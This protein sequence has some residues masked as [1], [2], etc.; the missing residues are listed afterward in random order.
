MARTAQTNLKI[1]NAGVPLTAGAFHTVNLLGSLSASDAGSNVAD[2]TGS[3]AA[4]SNVETEVVTGTQS[5]TDVTFDLT[6]LAHTF[7]SVE[8]VFRNGQA[9]KPTTDWI[10][11][12]NDLTIYSADAGEV[13]MIQYIY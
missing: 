3:S 6:G 1:K 11:T 2:V 7:V 8:V 13:F 4:G 9:L 12:G 10:L 5:G